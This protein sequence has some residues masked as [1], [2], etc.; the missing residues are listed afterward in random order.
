MII[1]INPSD[2]NYKMENCTIYSH[3]LAFDKIV[4]L[5]KQQFPKAK[6]E[7]NDG[8]KQKSLV[9]TIK[10]G[11]FSKAKGLTINYRERENPSYK[12]EQ[13]ECG[14]TQNLAGMANFIQ[15][16]PA[17]NEAI[18]NKFLYKVM[19]ANCEMAFIAEPVISGDLEKLLRQISAQLD[20]FLFAQP[21]K[22]F[23]KASGQ[24]FLDK[25]FQLILDTN[26][27]SQVED[28]SVVVD[29]KYH[30][31][32]A[33]DYSEQQLQRKDRSES[34]LNAHGIKVNKNLP[35][36]DN[37]DKTELRSHEDVIERALALT[38]VA[39]R[40]EGITKAQTQKSIT[41]KA[42]NGFS[43]KEEA[44]LANEDWNDQQKAYA[45]WR[46]ESLYTILWAL[47]VF[48][49]LK[50]PTEV[51]DVQQVVSKVLKPSREEFTRQTGM[52][53]KEE[54]LDELDKTYRMNWACVDARIKGEQVGGQ[55]NP[56]IIY[57]RHYALNWLTKYQDQ[58]WDQ[59]STDT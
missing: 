25:D 45:T 12:L 13:I 40:G 4:G 7:V 32:P 59:V 17:R 2:N 16:I 21:S 14:L 55:I 44:M 9:A 18:R 50:F 5:V 10:G 49:E 57:E 19:S 22:L 54:I 15:S 46:Y 24:H 1:R 58:A 52:R 8:G 23:N 30:D 26:G 36:T 48:P 34:V 3:Q 29:A 35:C 31:E 51:C 43:P 53:T 56:S 6:V 39:A 20:V 37:D 41:D 11:L 28:V 47:K 33:S 42:I 38:I 27:N